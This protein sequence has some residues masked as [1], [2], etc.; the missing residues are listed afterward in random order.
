MLI[1]FLHTHSSA[2]KLN[3]HPSIYAGKGDV[4]CYVLL[5]QLLDKLLVQSHC[6]EHGLNL[7]QISILG[8]FNRQ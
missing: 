2:D 6:Y 1:R 3:I 4:S 8:Q 5:N 7:L